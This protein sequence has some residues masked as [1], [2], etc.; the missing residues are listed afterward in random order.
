MGRFES[1]IA[2]QPVPQTKLK[3]LV[4]SVCETV[5][6]PCFGLRLVPVYQDLSTHHGWPAKKAIGD[7]PTRLNG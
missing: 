1:L 4:K 6:N 2:D 7:L 5:P 3:S